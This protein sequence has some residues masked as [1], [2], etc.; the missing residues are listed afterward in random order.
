MIPL[1]SDLP[2]LTHLHS[3]Y[4]NGKSTD[5]SFPNILQ[6]SAFHAL[7]CLTLTARLKDLKQSLTHAYS[8][9]SLMLLHVS[10]SYQNFHPS[11][12]SA[13]LS[14]QRSW[15][16]FLQLFV[17]LFWES[18]WRPR[19]WFTYVAVTVGVPPD[20]IIH[21]LSWI[22]PPNEPP[23]CYS[24]HSGMAWTDMPVP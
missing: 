2:L 14:S 11:C 6:L 3:H 19:H 24:A 16:Q 12:F 5:H 22:L 20:N 8:P 1:L 7:R 23:W 4:S 18:S 10:Q 15:P 13:L 21:D 17:V 9:S